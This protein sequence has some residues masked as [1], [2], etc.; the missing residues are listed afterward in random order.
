M[1]V[2]VEELEVPREKAEEEFKA[3]REAFRRN[4]QLRREE[5]RRELMSVYGHLRHGKKLIDVYESF[6]RAGLNVDGDP[7]LAICRAD[8]KQCFCLKIEDGSAIFSVERLDR[9]IRQPRKTLGDVKLP[10]G[11]FQWQPIDQTHPLNTYNIKNQVV[12]CPAPIIPAKILV[13]EV[14]HR[15]RNYHVLWEVDGW[16]P[17]PPKDP[18]LLKRLTPNLFAA[19]ATWDLTPIERAIVRGHMYV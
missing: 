6:K 14:T 12:Q 16:K 15:L 13:E 10:E 17:V 5:I 3:L 18:M 8:T 4:A 2:K 19:L 7:R 11:T 9:W 1:S